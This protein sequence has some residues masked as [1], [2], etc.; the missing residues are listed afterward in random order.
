MKRQNPTNQNVTTRE[1]IDKNGL[2][3]SRENLHALL[4]SFYLGS[5][6]SI[7]SPGGSTI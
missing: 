7:T 5:I 3:R 6:T 1:I 2:L 4:L